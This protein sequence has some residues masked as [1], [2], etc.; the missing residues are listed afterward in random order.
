MKKRMA[1]WFMGEGSK[2][3]VVLFIIILAACYYVASHPI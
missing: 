1:E 3:D 2:V